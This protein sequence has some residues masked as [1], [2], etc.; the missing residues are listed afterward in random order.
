MFDQGAPKWKG[1]NFVEQP[2]TPKR[3]LRVLQ[4]EI[5]AEQAFPGLKH[6]RKEQAGQH[7]VVV[8]F[9]VPNVGLLVNS[10]QA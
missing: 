6:S 8:R 4:R 3:L 5:L 10:F 2:S 7:A 1:M 9:G